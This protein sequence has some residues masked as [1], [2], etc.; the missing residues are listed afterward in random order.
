MHRVCLDELVRYEDEVRPGDL[1][2]LG[3]LHNSN[4]G[5]GL[6]QL[7]RSGPRGGLMPLWDELQPELTAASGM[8]VDGAFNVCIAD[9]DSVWEFAPTATSRGRPVAL[10]GHWPLAGAVDCQYDASGA[11]TAL[12][13][14]QLHA[15]DRAAQSFSPTGEATTDLYRTID[16]SPQRLKEGADLLDALVPEGLQAEP[17][18]YIVSPDYVRRPDGLVVLISPSVDYLIDYHLRVLDPTHGRVHRLAWEKI[19]QEAA[20]MAVVPG[21]DGADPWI[22]PENTRLPPGPDGNT[23]PARR[24]P[25]SPPEEGPS[26]GDE[27]TGCQK[28]SSNPNAPPR[29]LGLLLALVIGGLAFL[30]RR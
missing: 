14:G 1:L 27:N 2:V 20:V 11:L 9:G 26:A 8:D 22:T 6:Y 12:V 17:D 24:D 23:G 7:Y 4:A 13:D 10:V 30:R 18:A 15:F 19:A 16:G 28:S 29:S 3:Y 5:E 25:P 21:G